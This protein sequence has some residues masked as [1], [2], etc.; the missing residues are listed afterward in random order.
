VRHPLDQWLSVAQ[1][2]VFQERLGP[3]RFLRGASRFAESAVQT[4]FI[5]FED[6]THDSDL[7]LRQLCAGLELAFDPGYREKWGSYTHITGDVLPGRS[8]GDRIAPLSRLPMSEAERQRFCSSAH[9][10]LIIDS[11]GYSD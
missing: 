4:G 10:G 11:L 7:A 3:A 9:Y 1:Q 2:A 8:S 5:R 6:F